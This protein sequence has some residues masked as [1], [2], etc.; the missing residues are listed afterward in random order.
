MKTEIA[1][2]S[3]L[4]LLGLF[5]VNSFTGLFIGVPTTYAT[6]IIDGDTIEIAGEER[7]RLLGIDTPEKGQYFYEEARD[8][9]KDIIGGRE[10]VLEPDTTDRDKYDRLLRYVYVNRTELVNIMLVEEGLARVLVIPP[11][12]GYEEELLEAEA[13]ARQKLLGLWKYDHIEDAYCIGI[14][15]MR[16]N[17]MGDDRENLNDEYVEFRNSCEHDVDMGG[18]ELTDKAGHLY[19]FH[20]FTAP[21]KAKFRLRTGAGDDTNEDLYWGSTMPIWNNGGDT[22][23]VWNAGGEVVLRHEYEG[24]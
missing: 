7:V 2:V 20:G 10:I 5:Y 13:W 11:D 23:V 4:A 15:Y 24:Y 16:Y 19:G 17:A 12:R 3:A 14:F 21:A 18:W 8:R 22:V 9:L 1:L 6:R